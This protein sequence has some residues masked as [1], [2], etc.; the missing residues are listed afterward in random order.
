MNLR[1]R[2]ELQLLNE[3]E[4]D[5]SVTQRT[6]AKTLGV[7][8]GLTNLYLKRL[9]KKGYIKVTTIPRNRIKYLL[10]PHGIAEKSRLTYQY[11]QYSLYYYREVR[12]RLKQV[13]G[14]LSSTGSKRLVIYGTG[15]LAELAYLTLREMDLALVGFVNRSGEG[16]FLSYP[17]LPVMALSTCDFDAV[18][19][20]DLEDTEKARLQI[21]QEGVSREKIVALVPGTQGSISQSGSVV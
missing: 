12:E 6:L 15:E 13:L 7:A 16:T 4:K 10:T 5:G 2:R 17:L 1:S 21:V 19:I 18:L 14:D 9:I 11:M 8:L 20:A 3:L